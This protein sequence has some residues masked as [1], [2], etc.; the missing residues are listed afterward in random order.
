MGS[1][2][3]W[4]HIKVTYAQ[5]LHM[6]DD[7]SKYTTNS[8]LLIVEPTQAYYDCHL[9]KANVLSTYFMKDPYQPL[10]DKLPE[11]KGIF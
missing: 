7:G 9:P 10:R 4:T 11:L 6:Y 1:L 5:H 8:I 2:E 3:E